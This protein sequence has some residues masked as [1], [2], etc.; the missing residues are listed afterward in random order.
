MN[1]AVP[2]NR[3]DGRPNGSSGLSED[4]DGRHSMRPEADMRLTAPHER[5][6][7]KS[8]QMSDAGTSDW[9]L[10]SQAFAL[11]MAI[12]CAVYTMI[13]NVITKW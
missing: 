5:S 1:G 3:T 12:A 9:G 2:D 7:R 10:A 13:T 8:G 6:W 4:S 11:K